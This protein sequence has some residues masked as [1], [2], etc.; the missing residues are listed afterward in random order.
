MRGV[1]TFPLRPDTLPKDLKDKGQVQGPTWQYE[2]ASGGRSR[3]NLDFP[4]HLWGEVGTWWSKLTWSHRFPGELKG[5]TWLELLIDFELSTGINCCRPSKAATD[6]W[7]QRAELLR[8]IVK[9]M[10]KVRG[11]GSKALEN[12]YGVSPR[13]S[14][15]SVFGAKFLPGLSRR[16]TFVS[17]ARTPKATAV[18][19]WQWAVEGKAKIPQLHK[20]SYVGFVRGGEKSTEVAER[21][22]QKA[23][24]ANTDVTADDTLRPAARRGTPRRSQGESSST[25]SASFACMRTERA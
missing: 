23:C 12:D 2:L 18:N 20:V 5:V 16:P 21:L 13:V 9:L 1:C 4:L 22:A 11:G 19:A 3:I 25:C 6:S 24:E 10:L 8:H 7:G 17:G 15:L 14:S